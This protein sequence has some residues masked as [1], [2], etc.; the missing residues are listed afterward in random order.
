MARWSA[1]RYDRDVDTE[2]D[3]S[4]VVAAIVTLWFV[5]SG[6]YAAAVGL[7]A[8]RA[9]TYAPGLGLDVHGTAAA[10]AGWFTLVLALALLAAG[11]LVSYVELHG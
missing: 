9:R 2:V 5:V 3:M 4:A 6:G 11:V 10:V 7:S 8:I 1:P